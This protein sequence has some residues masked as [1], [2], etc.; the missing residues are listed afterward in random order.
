M[1][2]AAK[3]SYQSLPPLERAR[4]FESL[5]RSGTR[6]AQIARSLGK[7]L[8]YV[9]NTLRLLKLPILVQ[10]GLISGTITE[11]HARALLALNSEKQILAVYREIL[12]KNANVRQ[13]EEMVRKAVQ[14]KLSSS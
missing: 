13:T 8:A 5:V 9:S 11:G 4:A 6:P 2:D 12:V 3:A 7:S 1:D 10:E 14:E